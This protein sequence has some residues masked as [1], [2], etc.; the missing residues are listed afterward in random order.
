MI[1]AVIGQIQ[2]PPLTSP[3]RTRATLSFPQP[4]GATPRRFL[5]PLLSVPPP[6]ESAPQWHDLRSIQYAADAV[7]EG[8]CAAIDSLHT[9]SLRN[10][11]KH[12]PLLSRC[13]Y[14]RRRTADFLGLLD[15]S[16]RNGILASAS[17][18]LPPFLLPHSAPFRLV[19][20]RLNGMICAQ[21]TTPLPLY[22][23]EDGVGDYLALEKAG[24]NEYSRVQAASTPGFRNPIYGELNASV[25]DQAR[26]TRLIASEGLV[27]PFRP[28]GGHSEDDIPMLLNDAESQT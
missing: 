10:G 28:C 18:S 8:F 25:P 21:F 17:P 15:G 19:N 26:P 2:A 6:H 24:V 1:S 9:L 20:L 11:P 22:G 23:P 4:I 3:T 12:L 16:A 14:R 27:S 5:P 13:V 7:P